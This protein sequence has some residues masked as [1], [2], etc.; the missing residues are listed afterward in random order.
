M[1]STEVAVAKSAAIAPSPTPLSISGALAEQVQQMGHA[2]TLAQSICKTTL[3]P[4]HF[5]G[6]PEDGAVAIMAGA[7]WGL[8]A[9]AALQNIFIVH[10][11]PSTFAR[12]MKAV[13]QA[14]G[15]EIW[16]ETVEP[17]RVVVC[18]KRKGSDRIET[19]EWTEARARKAGYFSNK[20]YDTELEN[21]LYARATA[22]CARRTAPDCLLGMPY[23][24]EEMEDAKPVRATAERVDGKRISDDLGITREEP[25]ETVDVSHGEEVPYDEPAAEPASEPASDEPA[26]ELLSS[27]QLGKLQAL[28][29][30]EG[31]T[32]SEARHEWLTSN[33]RR[34]ITDTKQ[35]KKSEASEI[36]EFLVEAQSKDQR[37]N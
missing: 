7:K 32:T 9:I 29:K 18:G 15:H 27:A 37:G 24:R 8:D 30:K 28:L 4:A 16:T 22:E 5:R 17:G 11:T 33:L 2:Y 23:S 3:V 1:S 13:V 25:A 10:G 31:L 35:V 21:M 36:I 12:V 26:G 14:N 20:K 6:K 19:S 34:D